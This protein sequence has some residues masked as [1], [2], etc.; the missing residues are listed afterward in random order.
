[1]HYQDQNIALDVANLVRGQDTEDAMLRRL[2]LMGANRHLNAN[3]A[4]PAAAHAEIAGLPDVTA[5]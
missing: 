5:L 4:L 2:N 3:V 1:M